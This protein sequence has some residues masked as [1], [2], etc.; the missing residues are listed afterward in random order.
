MSKT[1]YPKLR[2]KIIEVY[3]SQKAF[4]EALGTTYSTL[5][6]KLSGEGDITLREAG[7]MSQL[8]GIT[9]YQAYFFEN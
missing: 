1:V 9:D 8:L 5:T 4:A 2:G 6:R 3:G 7:R